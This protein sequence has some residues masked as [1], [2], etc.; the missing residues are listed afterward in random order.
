MYYVLPGGSKGSAQASCTRIWPKTHPAGSDQTLGLHPWGNKVPPEVL[1]TPLSHLIVRF[2][3][4]GNRRTAVM[5]NFYTPTTLSTL[6][7][8][9]RPRCVSVIVSEA[10]LFALLATD[11]H[12][13]FPQ[14]LP[15]SPHGS[16]HHFSLRRGEQDSTLPAF[17]TSHETDFSRSHS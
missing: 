10:T 8:R 12:Q 16:S 14:P 7:L 1:K 2:L 4:L 15:N 5:L 11:P 9:P 17:M 6:S 3:P 13:P